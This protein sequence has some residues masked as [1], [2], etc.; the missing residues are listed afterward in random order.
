MMDK[1]SHFAVALQ[2]SPVVVDKLRRDLLLEKTTYVDIVNQLLINWRSSK[3]NMA[4]IG[5]LLDIVVE[6]FAWN[7][8]E[9]KK[10]FDV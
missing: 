6:N 9:G 10:Y 2:L 8:V 3:S 5:N 1:W 4:T 7:E